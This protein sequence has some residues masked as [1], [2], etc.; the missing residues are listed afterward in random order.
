MAFTIREAHEYLKTRP[1]ADAMRKK[2]SRGLSWRQ[3]CDWHLREYG[4]GGFPVWREPM[5]GRWLTLLRER[6]VKHD[7]ERA[8][9]AKQEPQYHKTFDDYR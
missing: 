9:T 7:D 1:A 2:D 8:P 3:F 5:P 6:W 4:D